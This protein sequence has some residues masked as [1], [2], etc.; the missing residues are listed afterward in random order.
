[1]AVDINPKNNTPFLKY[2]KAEID[3][4]EETY[5]VAAKNFVDALYACDS[6]RREFEK[7]YKEN[8]KGKAEKGQDKEINAPASADALPVK[9]GRKASS[10]I[11]N[12]FDWS[13][14]ENAQRPDYVHSIMKG[15]VRFD[16]SISVSGYGYKPQFH[17]V[18]DEGNP[19]VKD[20][21]CITPLDGCLYLCFRD[22]TVDNRRI[23]GM[24]NAIV[25]V[26][27]RTVGQ[28]NAAGNPVA[29]SLQVV[30]FKSLPLDDNLGGIGIG[31]WVS[32]ADADTGVK[33]EKV[34]VLGA[35]G[36]R[37]WFSNFDWN[38]FSKYCD[39][40]LQRNPVPLDFSNDK[41]SIIKSKHL[42]LWGM[43]K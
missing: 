37:V 28:R 42:P 26:D 35:E 36:N 11:L 19:Y 32:F 12:I 3:N 24:F 10:D 15:L 23:P 34:N 25:T 40:E 22:N 14:F 30:G 39:A 43:K 31:G 17:M 38:E 9:D 16:K 8:K 7:Y 6:I 20:S 2:F 41:E 4:L 21:S 27:Y 29:P 33:K 5:Q 13:K 18:N 1:M